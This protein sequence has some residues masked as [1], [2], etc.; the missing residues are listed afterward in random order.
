VASLHAKK[1]SQKQC[2]A[3]KMN[4][5]LISDPVQTDFLPSGAVITWSR[6]E[7]S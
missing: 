7:S 2:A 4:L 6:F 3:L 1:M 5:G